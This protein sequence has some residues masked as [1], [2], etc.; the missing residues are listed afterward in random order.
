V[1]VTVTP[2]ISV[3][4]TGL[5]T[6][7]YAYLDKFG[8]TG[9]YFDRALFYKDNGK[10]KEFKIEIEKSYNQVVSDT[11]ELQGYNTSKVFEP[12]RYEYN[13]AIL[14]ELSAVLV[15]KFYS[16]NPTGDPY[17]RFNIYIN[18]ATDHTYKGNDALKNITG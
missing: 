5:T 7:D 1:Y 3:S 12:V 18:D 17:P 4:K 11:R 16:E 2:T 6:E 14:N 13:Q 15:L 9:D 10:F 8:K